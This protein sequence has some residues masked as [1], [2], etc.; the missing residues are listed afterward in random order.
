MADGPVVDEVVDGVV[1][2]FGK[3]LEIPTRDFC[4][5]DGVVVGL[6]GDFSLLFG[7]TLLV[8]VVDEVVDVDFVGLLCDSKLNCANFPGLV[9]CQR[10]HVDR[11]ESDVTR[12]LSLVSV[13]SWGIYVCCHFP[14]RPLGS[15]AG[16]SAPQLHVTSASRS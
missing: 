8:G 7:A 2:V 10:C 3:G 5:V 4:V 12:T 1:D 14:S 9:T 6:M 13:S 15:C 16:R 11:F